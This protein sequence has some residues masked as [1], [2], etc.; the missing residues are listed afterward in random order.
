MRGVVPVSENR[1][2]YFF[3]NRHFFEE[4]M[5]QRLCTRCEYFHK[6]GICGS[7]DP[8]GCAVFRYLPQLVMIAQHM[9][10]PTVDSYIE[11]VRQNVP[12]ECKNTDP[13]SVCRLRDTLE[14]GLDQYIPLILEAVLEE[15]AILEHR[16][17]F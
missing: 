14:C 10:D 11:A 13:N 6:E 4:A 1:K 12:M 9:K 16:E 17:G 15:D 7:P 5:G 3:W 2:T 8:K